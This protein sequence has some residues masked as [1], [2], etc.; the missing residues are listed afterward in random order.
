MNE[1][2]IKLKTFFDKDGFYCP[3]CSILN[4]NAI[5][6]MTLK[7]NFYKINKNE[8]YKTIAFIKCINCKNY[9][10]NGD[11]YGYVKNVTEHIN[12]YKELKDTIDSYYKQ[13]KQKTKEIK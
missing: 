7:K 2:S 9:F 10:T 12:G 5:Y 4:I 13:C 8:K 3:K 11:K 6:I 1:K